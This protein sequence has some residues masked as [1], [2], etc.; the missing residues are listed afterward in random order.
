LQ[1]RH[2][3]I[4]CRTGAS[5]GCRDKSLQCRGTL[6]ISSLGEKINVAEMR[7]VGYADSNRS[8]VRYARSIDGHGDD[9]KCVPARKPAEIEIAGRVRCLVLENRARTP[10][11]VL[12]PHRDERRASDNWS[13]GP[14]IHYLPA[15]AGVARTHLARREHGLE[16][17]LP[18]SFLKNRS[19]SI[20]VD[21][22][23]HVLPGGH[24]DRPSHNLSRRNFQSRVGLAGELKLMNAPIV[25]RNAVESLASA[26]IRRRHWPAPTIVGSEYQANLLVGPGRQGGVR[27][28]GHE[29]ARS[30]ERKQIDLHWRV[31]QLWRQLLP[32]WAAVV[33]SGAGV[34]LHRANRHVDMIERPMW[35]SAA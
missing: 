29:Q 33:R 8:V 24:R 25:Q 22:E 26:R 28:K 30:R 13:P 14:R 4:Y 2:G 15:N 35:K 27:T 7:A 21:V 1:C 23:I 32:T 11:R 18:V 12:L 16:P 3:G 31:V 34:R 5:G 19:A 10:A 17:I 9:I 20:E 6:G